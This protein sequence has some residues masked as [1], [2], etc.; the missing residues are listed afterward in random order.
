MVTDT[1]GP[2]TPA[3]LKELFGDSVPYEQLAAILWDSSDDRTIGDV[4]A[5]VRSLA[6]QIKEANRA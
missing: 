4:R 3:E 1:T 5:E 2:I 6:A